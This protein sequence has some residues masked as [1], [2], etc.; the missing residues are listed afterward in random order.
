MRTLEE[1]IEKNINYLTK[2]KEMAM[3]NGH[4]DVANQ[5]QISINV[6][7]GTLNEYKNQTSCSQ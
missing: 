5:I 4:E 7:L 3:S 1:V 2:G 6:L